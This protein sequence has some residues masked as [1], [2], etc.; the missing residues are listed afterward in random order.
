MTKALDATIQKRVDEGIEKYLIS[1][2][3][4]IPKKK[5]D[6]AIT[7]KRILDNTIASGFLLEVEIHQQ[8]WSRSEKWY[9]EVQRPFW[10]IDYKI[11]RHKQTEQYRDQGESAPVGAK[12]RLM[13]IVASRSQNLIKDSIYRRNTISVVIECKR[14]TKQNLVFYEEEWSKVEIDNLLLGIDEK[15]LD[16]YILAISKEDISVSRKLYNCIGKTD[17]DHHHSSSNLSRIGLSGTGLSGKQQ[18]NSL[19][20]AC[21]AVTDAADY[22]ALY[23]QKMTDYHTGAFRLGQKPDYWRLYPV[24]VYDGPIW[25]ISKSD[26]GKLDIDQASFVT[27]CL[28]KGNRPHLIDI[29]HRNEFGNYLTI[30][31]E[32]LEGTSKILNDI[33]QSDE[34]GFD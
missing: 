16:D 27:Y 17:S 6:K 11:P 13:D 15:S 22:F 3:I 14:H 32:E 12:V 8:L 18:T 19:R 20:E 1:R 4:E 10:D 5:D 29:V 33:K 31:D 21:A 30:L 7:K 25:A 24:L 9:A 23:Y 26:R 34:M 2:G 28:M